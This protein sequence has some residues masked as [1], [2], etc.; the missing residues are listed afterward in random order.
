MNPADINSKFT[1][2]VNPDVVVAGKTQCFILL[3]DK[4]RLATYRKKTSVLFRGVMVVGGIIKTLAVQRVKCSMLVSVDPFAILMGQLQEGDRRSNDAG[5]G[6]THI[7]P[8]PPLVK[9]RL[10]RISR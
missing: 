7:G 10:R 4:F 5:V 1:V 2:D 6:N 9:I 8:E 3:I